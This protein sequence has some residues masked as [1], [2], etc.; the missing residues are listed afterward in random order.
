MSLTHCCAVLRYCCVSPLQKQLPGVPLP[1]LP[2]KKLVGK[3]VPGFVLLYYCTACEALT[4]ALW[5][6][7]EQLR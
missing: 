4:H 7:R 3:M 1:K 2:G 6:T 5:T